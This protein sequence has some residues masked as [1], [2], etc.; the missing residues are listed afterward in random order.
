MDRFGVYLL[1]RQ[2]LKQPDSR[3]RALLAEAIME[4]LADHNDQPREQWAILGLFSQIDLE[5]A[6]TNPEVRGLAARQHALTEGIAPEQADH[7]S[8]WCAHLRPAQQAMP[9]QPAE[10]ALLL[11]DHLAQQVLQNRQADAAGLERDLLLA[12]QQ[13]D[14]RSERLEQSLAG[15]QLEPEQAGRLAQKALRRIEEDLR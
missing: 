6:A 10:L 14:A 3:N 12:V 4:E 13:G 11:A 2:Y 15:L 1:V 8:G 5:Y 7:L 9:M